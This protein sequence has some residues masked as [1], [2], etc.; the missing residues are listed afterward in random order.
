MKSSK[1]ARRRSN[2]NNWGKGV[3]RVGKKVILYSYELTCY[4]VYVS[5]VK[6]KKETDSRIQKKDAN[7]FRKKS[8]LTKARKREKKT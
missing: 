3:D 4:V 1:H 6:N 2:K 8:N 5:S 7:R